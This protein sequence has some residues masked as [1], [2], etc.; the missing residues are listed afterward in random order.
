LPDGPKTGADGDGAEEAD[1]AIVPRIITGASD[2]ALKIW[3]DATAEVEDEAIG[4]REEFV[5]R[6]QEMLNAYR[7]G[8]YARAMTIA[9]EIDQPLRLRGLLE[10]LVEEN[11]LDKHVGAV[12]FTPQTLTRFLLYIR[13]WNT[14]AR[15]CEVAQQ[16]LSFVLKTFSF[17]QLRRAVKE[18]GKSAQTK[19]NAGSSEEGVTS[20]HEIVAGLVAYSE[21]HLKRSARVYQ[22]SFVV[23]Y[24]LKSMQKLLPQQELIAE[25]QTAASDSTSVADQL[26]NET[27][28]AAAGDSDDSSS[29]SS[30]SDDDDDDDNKV[31]KTVVDTK[32][33]LDAGPVAPPTTGNA[34]TSDAST[35]AKGGRRRRR[36]RSKKA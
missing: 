1:A 13:D 3:Y 30:S 4:Q 31:P 26:D 32:E 33:A 21:R 8:K 6:E 14:N 35:T 7:S 20:V 36:R 23:E 15:F 24:T 18:A 5:L 10:K 22:S 28:V 9:L 25:T 2:S 27:T 34:T 16:S 12:V 11:S 19:G 29:S 17:A